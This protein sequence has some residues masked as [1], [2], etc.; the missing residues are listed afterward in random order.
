MYVQYILP[1][2]LK[3]SSDISKKSRSFI[4]NEVQTLNVDNGCPLFFIQNL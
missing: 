1:A 3:L 2:D 4:K